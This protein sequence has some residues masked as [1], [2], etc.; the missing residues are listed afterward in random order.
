MR[1]KNLWL[2]Y[3][4]A[5]NRDSDV[6][7]LAQEIRSQDI[8]VIIDRWHIAPGQSLWKQIEDGICDSGRSDAWAIFATE[9]SFRSMGCREEL[10]W[11]LNRA[12]AA[13]DDA[14]PIIGIFPGSLP[15]NL[16]PAAIKVRRY[17]TLEEQDWLKNIVAGVHGIAPEN[18]AL[19]LSSTFHAFHMLAD[20]KIVLELRPRV[21]TWSKFAVGVPIAD[22]T[23]FNWVSFGAPNAPV[24]S[25]MMQ[26]LDQTIEI[27]PGQSWYFRKF[28]HNLPSPTLSA[29]I[30]LAGM[31]SAL[32]AGTIEPTGLRN[33]FSMEANQL[34]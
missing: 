22:K 28:F 11:A 30:H 26:S 8:N 21:G 27:A 7:F 19:P 1:K 17:V 24:M 9:Q 32:T 29:Y 34:S 20:G 12:L 4:W 3:A 14:F 5:D 15:Q 18:S 25:G 33:V 23:V 10:D 2:T 13:R 6:E 31:P 16:I